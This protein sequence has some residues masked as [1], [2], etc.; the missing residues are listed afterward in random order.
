MRLQVRK[1]RIK[2]IIHKGRPFKALCFGQKRSGGRNNTGRITAPHRGGGAKRLIRIIDWKRNDLHGVEGEVMRVEYDPGRT[3][4]IAL[5]KYD[6]APAGRVLSSWQKK[7]SGEVTGDEGAIS[8]YRYIVAPN[9]IKIGDKIC[10][11]ADIEARPGN[12]M[13]L[14]DV[15]EGMMVHNIELYP[16]QGAQIARAAGAFARITGRDGDLVNLKMRS[17]EIRSFS[18]NC[19]ATIGVV[20][21]IEHFN[22]TIGK[23]GTNVNRGRR[24]HVRGIAMNPVDHHNGGRTNGGKCLA[25]FNG[26]CIKGKKTRSPKKLSNRLIVRRAR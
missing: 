3:A 6:A 13:P 5:V 10:S 22:E 7:H 9:G 18:K 1:V 16:G 17:G 14:K 21:N 25:N 15:P 20:S 4:R 8:T 24:P 2:G 26:K 11:G 19:M 12:A 23:A